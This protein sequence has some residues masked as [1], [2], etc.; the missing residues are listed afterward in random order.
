MHTSY[1]VLA[2][3]KDFKKLVCI[4]L[5][6]AYGAKDSNLL[7]YLP[8]HSGYCQYYRDQYVTPNYEATML[9]ACRMST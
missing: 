1:Y 2:R 5:P 6:Y 7:Y 8:N 3:F 9:A 4:M